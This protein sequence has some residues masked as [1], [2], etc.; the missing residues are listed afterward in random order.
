[1]GFLDR[2]LGRKRSQGEGLDSIYLRDVG[3]DELKGK[4]ASTSGD[5]LSLYESGL[6]PLLEAGD[7]FIVFGQD[8][9]ER[10][11][12][13]AADSPSAGLTGEVGSQGVSDEMDEMLRDLGFT[14]PDNSNSNYYRVFEEIDA[15]V[16]AELV[17]K[18]FI[19]TLGCPDT[20]TAEVVA[21]ESH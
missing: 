16:L 10:F 19:D 4:R 3:L 13:F 15:P 14:P 2:L 12:Q 18:I 17:E 11:V 6:R 7:G 9:D 8:T 21:S 20:Y 5:R 1:V